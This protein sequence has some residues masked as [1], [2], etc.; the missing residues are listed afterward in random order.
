L[1]I[2]SFSCRPRT[3]AFFIENLQSKYNGQM[4][5]QF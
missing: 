3:I 5:M 4:Y 1:D 2:L